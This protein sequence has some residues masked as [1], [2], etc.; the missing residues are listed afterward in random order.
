MLFKRSNKVTLR[1]K[2]DYEELK[3][4]WNSYSLLINKEIYF[5]D[6]ENQSFKGIVKNITKYGSLL[7]TT[8]NGEEK[9]LTVGE[10][11]LL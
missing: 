6:F 7:V 10:I 2:K 11:E 5:K 4:E 1:T 9:E 8:L 3:E